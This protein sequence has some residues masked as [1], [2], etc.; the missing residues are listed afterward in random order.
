MNIDTDAIKARLARG[1]RDRASRV[2]HRYPTVELTESFVDSLSL[3]GRECVRISPPRESRGYERAESFVSEFFDQQETGRRGDPPVYSFAPTYESGRICFYASAPTGRE[4]DIRDAVTGKYAGADIRPI[5][6][7]LP[8]GPGGYA[9]GARLVLYA[10]ALYPLGTRQTSEPVIEDPHGSIL[11]KLVGGADETAML[12]GVFR[13]IGGRWFNRGAFGAGGDRVAESLRNGTSVGHINPE[14]ITPDQT[15]N[16]ASDIQR[17]R[18]RDAFTVTLR[19]LA[20]GPDRAT[21]S[22]RVQD[23]VG[24]LNAVKN[25]ATEQWLVAHP[26][27]GRDL[28]T[29]IQSM[30]GRWPSETGI[31]RLWSGQQTVLTDEELGGFLVHLPAENDVDAPVEWSEDAESSRIPPDAF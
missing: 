30:A 1:A 18:G 4:K 20:T 23:I 15:K 19:V 8:V 27:S 31:R 29:H 14:I 12:Q 17:Q 5:D 21:A 9:A 22:Q 6:E 7:A 10:D 13:S 2:R 28:R 25:P 11:P 3:R 16:A 24:S 26:R